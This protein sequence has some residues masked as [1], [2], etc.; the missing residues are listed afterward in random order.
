[1][2]LAPAAAKEFWDRPLSNSDKAKEVSDENLDKMI[3]DLNP[4]LTSPLRYS[5]KVSFLLGMK[6]PR[7]QFLIGMG[8]GKTYLTLALFANNEAERC[9]VCVPNVVNLAEW[10]NQ[11]QRHYPSMKCTVI[12]QKGS[13]ARWKALEEGDLCVIT[14]QG[15]S[16]LLCDKVPGRRGKNKWEPSNKKIRDIGKLFQML[17]HDESTSIKNPSGLPFRIARKLSK[18]VHYLYNLTGTP[19]DKDPIDLW[20]QFRIID[21]GHSL[22][23]TLGL[24]RAV[25][26]RQ[27]DTHWGVTWEFKK[28][29]KSRLARRLRHRSIRFS[30]A[31]CQDLPPAQGGL[32]GDNLMIL[33]AIMPKAHKKYYDALEKEFTSIQTG[34]VDAIASAYTRMRMVSSGWLGAKDSEG[35]RVEI[36]FKDNPKLDAVISKI[37]ELDNEKVVVVHWFNHSGQIIADRLKKEKISFAHVYGKTPSKK[38]QAEL[39]RFRKPSG[40]QVL[41]ASNA[42][43]KGVNLQD[44]CRYMIFFESP[45]SLIERK[46]MEA[47]IQREGE[48]KG[49]RYYYDATTVGTKDEDI[50]AALKLGEDVFTYIVNRSTT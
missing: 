13:E 25:M 45:D 2:V 38:K 6:Y 15:L 18:H 26:F 42:I 1:M 50:L 40:P 27:V 48:L 29:E 19:F 33:P 8:G 16:G 28:N 39:D 17:V 43:S 4:W 34:T 30:E 20:S 46:Q 37:Q 35:E 49:H 23:E 9:L 31:E 3:A 24:Y 5:Q 11:T 12:D 21:N 41:L 36:T 14:Y 32:A 44:A 7:Y 10:A 47:R 22:G